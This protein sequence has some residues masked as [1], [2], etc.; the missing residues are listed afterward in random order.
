MKRSNLTGLVATVA[1]AAA[2]GGCSPGAQP[3]ALISVTASAEAQTTPDIATINAGVESRGSTAKAAQEAQATRMAAVV[4]AL[5]AQGV[6]D[7]DIQTSQIGLNPIV[8]YS[9]TG[10][11][12]ITGYSSVNTVTITVRDLDK[13]S[14]IIDAIVADG[15]NRIDGI[16]FSMDDA[17]KAEAE[18]HAEAIRKAR[19]RAEGYAAGAGLKVHRLVSIVEPGGSSMPP[20]PMDGMAFKAVAESTATPIMPGQV[21]TGAAVTVVFELR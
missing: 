1:M 11:Q 12:R 17:E 7:K 9:E 18:A 21:T 3:G 4:A 20:M 16:A 8:D 15:G 6:N 5:K 10:Q 19:A 2:L 14:S 13:V